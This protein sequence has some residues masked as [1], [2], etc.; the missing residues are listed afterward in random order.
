MR[1]IES[2]AKRV[3]KLE[4]IKQADERPFVMAVHS[5]SITLT[6]AEIDRMLKQIDGKTRGIPCQRSSARAAFG[7]IAHDV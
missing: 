1:R 4:A 6:G 2:L 7:G 3:A 5:G